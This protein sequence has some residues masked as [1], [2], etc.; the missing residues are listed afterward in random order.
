MQ[1][2]ANRD[3][4]V[5]PVALAGG[6][7]GRPLSVT[8]LCRASPAAAP[9]AANDTDGGVGAAAPNAANDTDGGVGA[10]ASACA[11]AVPHPASPASGGGDI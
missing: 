3:G 2:E 8:G 5:H 1:R 10:A 7:G 9:N 11:E 6:A 4:C